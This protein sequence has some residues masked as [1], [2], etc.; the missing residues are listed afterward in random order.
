MN[1]ESSRT[2]KRPFIKRNLEVYVIC[3]QSVLAEACTEAVIHDDA[4]ETALLQGEKFNAKKL[5]LE[6]FFPIILQK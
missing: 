5:S 4:T 2:Y 3:A 1:G 6:L